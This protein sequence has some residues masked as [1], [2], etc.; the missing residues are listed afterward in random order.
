MGLTQFL[1]NRWNVPN[2]RHWF[3]LSFCCLWRRWWWSNLF[4]HPGHWQSPCSCVAWIIFSKAPSLPSKSITNDGRGGKP[5]KAIA[6]K[7]VP[8][9]ARD[10]PPLR[11]PYLGF[12]TFKAQYIRLAERSN[13]PWGFWRKSAPMWPEIL[14][15]PILALPSFKSINKWWPRAQTPRLLPKSP[16]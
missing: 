11:L 2:C 12:V 6:I 5:P 3:F 10:L 16:H 8:T 9:T 15:L 13:P 1:C 7:S 4:C 14:R